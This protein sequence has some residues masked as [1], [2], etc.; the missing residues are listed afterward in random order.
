MMANIAYCQSFLDY[1]L[2]CVTRIAPALASN[3]DIRRTKLKKKK[4]TNGRRCVEVYLRS[5]CPF[6]HSGIFFNLVS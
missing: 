3:F 1:I 2:L 4:N 5:S 6:F